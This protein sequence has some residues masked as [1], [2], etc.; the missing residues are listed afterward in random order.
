MSKSNSFISPLNFLCNFLS[1]L[2]YFSWRDCVEL[3][4][5]LLSVLGRIHQWNRGD[6]YFRRL[7]NKNSLVVRVLL[8][9]L[10]SPWVDFGSLGY[11]NRKP[12][13]GSL[14]PCML[15]VCP[16]CKAPMILYLDPF[17]WLCCC[18]QHWAN[19]SLST[20]SQF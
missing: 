10:S 20:Q 16:K 12:T 19:V 18:E 2:L 4:L 15:Q 1:P 5:F 17:S 13:M 14:Q 6:F 7:L 3:V 11:W 8:W 9:T